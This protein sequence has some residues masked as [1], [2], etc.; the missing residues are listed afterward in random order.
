MP[1]H[2][3]GGGCARGPRD[4]EGGPNSG[5]RCEHWIEEKVRQKAALMRAA[6]DAWA[7]GDAD[8]PSRRRCRS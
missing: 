2:N 5:E 1:F 3:D 4:R 7:R 6:V 8:K